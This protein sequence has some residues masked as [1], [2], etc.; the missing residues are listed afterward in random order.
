MIIPPLQFHC[1]QH[2]SYHTVVGSSTSDLPSNAA[3]QGNL[4]NRRCLIYCS[5]LLCLYILIAVR[6]PNHPIKISLG[7]FPLLINARPSYPYSTFHIFRSI[8][9]LLTVTKT[10]KLSLSLLSSPTVV[11]P[12]TAHS[13][14]FLFQSSPVWILPL[15]AAVMVDIVTVH[16]ATVSAITPILLV[17][18][19]SSHSISS[20]S[21][22]DHILL[23]H[24]I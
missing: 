23:L 12:I 18:V 9:L 14:V 11:I 21:C 8:S 10:K 2:L 19:S 24:N 20:C 16:R 17:A 22:R 15:V 3:K 1:Y 5:R 6:K 7:S 4:I 13:L